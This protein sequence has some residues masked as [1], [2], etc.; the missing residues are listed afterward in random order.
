MH[1]QNAIDEIHK[2]HG[3]VD[4]KSNGMQNRPAYISHL[5]HVISIHVLKGKSGIYIP[6]YSFSPEE[7]EF[8][9]P[10]NSALKINKEPQTEVHHDR[11]T[12]LVKWKAELFHDGS[13]N[14]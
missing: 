8:I 11:D 14:T 3:H 2:A 6:R 10:R 12:G 13:K 1:H 4:F 5:R 7:R 9:L